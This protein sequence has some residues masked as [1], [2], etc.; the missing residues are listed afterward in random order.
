MKKRLFPVLAMFM[1]LSM[2]FVGCSQ[3]A[4][5]KT[6]D[7]DQANNKELTLTE[8]MNK[9]DEAMTKQKGASYKMDGKQKM[10]AMGMTIDTDFSFDINVTNEPQAMY[11]K[12]KMELMGQS[13]P[14]EMYFVDNMMYQNMEGN[15]VKMN[16][17][18]EMMDQMAKEKPS[19]TFKKL[20]ALLKKIG[21]EKEPKG[22]TMKKENGTYVV[23][24]DSTQLEG[25]QNIF[26]E[27]LKEMQG[28]LGASTKE[29]KDAGMNIDYSKMKIDKIK[30]AMH[31]DEKTFELKFVDQ[32]IK[33]TVPMDQENFVIEQTMKATV[34]GA[35]D[36]KI[37]VPEDVKKKAT[38]L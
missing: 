19:D 30:Q 4:E 8:V 27:M 12:G 9:A 37:E 7:A 36:G 13:M 2:I 26:D 32:E 17:P 28:Q 6:A 23:T 31:I 20:D 34:N 14:M 16:A 15:W 35:F 33:M 25:D 11:M 22:V 3:P 10:G 29:L 5:N 24:I 18:A 1:V 38:S 21:V